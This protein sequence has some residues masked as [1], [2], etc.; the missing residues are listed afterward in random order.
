MKYRK[1]P[2][3]IE[4]TQ[5]MKPGDHFAVEP[6]NAEIVF[7]CAGNY[8]YVSHCDQA[9]PMAT[10]WLAVH[11]EGDI[12]KKNGQVL[13]FE[14]YEVKSGKREPVAVRSDLLARYMSFSGWSHG[15]GDMGYIKTLEG[16]H[17][18]TPGDWIITGV[19]GELYPCKPDIFAATYELAE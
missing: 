2:I 4:A 16:G 9:V 17:I 8:Y 19:K 10:A 15:P 14:L 3:V 13:P 1:K 5:W 6:R 12:A 18:V 11:P 7:D